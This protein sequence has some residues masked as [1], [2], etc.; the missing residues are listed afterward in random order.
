MVHTLRPI[1]IGE[2]LAAHGRSRTSPWSTRRREDR[3]TLKHPHQS[4]VCNG[5]AHNSRASLQKRILA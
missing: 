3:A 1:L 2:M 4:G 5:V